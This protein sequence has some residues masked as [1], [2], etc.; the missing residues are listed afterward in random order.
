[1][2]MKK[3]EKLGIVN[4]ITGARRNRLYSYIS[5]MKILNKGTE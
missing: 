4:E 1:M 2:V 5:Y 3:F